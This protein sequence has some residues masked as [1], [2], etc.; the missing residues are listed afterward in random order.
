MKKTPQKKAKQLPL[1][2]WMANY[3]SWSFSKI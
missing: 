3:Q 1:S 2:E